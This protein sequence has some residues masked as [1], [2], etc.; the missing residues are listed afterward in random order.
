M[1]AANRVPDP[2]SATPGLDAVREGAAR[3]GRLQRQYGQVLGIGTAAS[4]LERTSGLLS[5]SGISIAQLPRH[6]PTEPLIR[7]HQN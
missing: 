4:I 6:C 5:S 2:E 1:S 7:A 3:P